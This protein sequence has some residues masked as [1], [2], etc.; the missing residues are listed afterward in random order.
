[1]AFLAC[2]FLLLLAVLGFYDAHMHR[3]EANAL[4]REVFD[5]LLCA[6]RHESAALLARRS[7]RLVSRLHMGFPMSGAERAFALADCAENSK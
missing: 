7:L 3:K 5:A 6:S 1:M 2:M 4:R